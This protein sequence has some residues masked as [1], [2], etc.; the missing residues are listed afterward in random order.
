M[1]RF[2]QEQF[3]QKPQ[4]AM[5]MPLLIGLDGTHK[6]SKSLGNYIGLNESASQAF[7]KLMS[8]SDKLCGI[9]FQYF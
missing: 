5:T 1:G 7:G 9:I 2:L 4:I 6:M 3:N 8:I